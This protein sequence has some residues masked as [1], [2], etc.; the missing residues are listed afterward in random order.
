MVERI[1]AQLEG[2]SWKGGRATLVLR[3]MVGFKRAT[4]KV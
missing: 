3:A 2:L 4:P 1:A